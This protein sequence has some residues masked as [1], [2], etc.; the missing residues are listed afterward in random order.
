MLKVYNLIGQEIITLVNKEQYAGNYSIIWNG[1][2]NHNK[3]VSSV[4]YFYVLKTE[5][6]SIS[7]KMLLLK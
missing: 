3:Q 6:H 2:D 1:K 5:N 4:T 7:K